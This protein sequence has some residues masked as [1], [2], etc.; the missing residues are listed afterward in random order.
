MY[1][2]K[3]QHNSKITKIEGKGINFNIGILV[4]S[5]TYMTL[6]NNVCACLNSLGN[7]SSL[8]SHYQ[9]PIEIPCKPH[10]NLSLHTI[11]SQTNLVVTR[12]L[13]H[14]QLWVHC[15][16]IPNLYT[17]VESNSSSTISSL[18]LAKG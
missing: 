4:Y 2:R 1:T 7:S 11:T 15:F 13:W 10:L 17:T 18:C 14:V 8:L 6:E 12:L 5:P 3:I 9:L 16:C